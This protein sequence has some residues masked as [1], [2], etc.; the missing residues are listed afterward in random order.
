MHGFHKL[1]A[2]GCPDG[3]GNL[4]KEETKTFEKNV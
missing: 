2:Y 3:G 4:I 1:F